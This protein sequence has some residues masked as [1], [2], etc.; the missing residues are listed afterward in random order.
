MLPQDRVTVRELPMRH[1]SRDRAGEARRERQLDR[2]AAQ[3]AFAIRIMD[4]GGSVST[5]KALVCPVGA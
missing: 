1:P 4:S 5:M 2:P 3:S